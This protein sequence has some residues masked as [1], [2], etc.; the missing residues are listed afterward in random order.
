V[1]IDEKLALEVA[2]VAR[3]T[4]FSRQTVT[5]MFENEPGVIIMERP[6]Q[7]RKRKYRSLRIPRGVYERVVAKMSVRRK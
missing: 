5:R 1:S 6:E 2:D 7:M 4:G 3:L